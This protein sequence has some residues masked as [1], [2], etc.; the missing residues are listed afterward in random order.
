MFGSDNTNKVKADTD[1]KTDEATTFVVSERSVINGN[2][3]TNEPTVIGGT[4]EGSVSIENSFVLK[5]KGAIRG[6]V[7]C[8]T[9]DVAGSINGNLICKGPVVLHSRA[10]LT[11]DLQ[12][13]SLVL[14]KGVYFCGKVICSELQPE[15]VEET[16][17]AV[18]ILAKSEQ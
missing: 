9:A 18:N 16:A 12:C 17:E 13:T 2:V 6:P 4:I 14:E 3:N 8:M 7:Y 10:I 11:G 1:K 5:E 15:K